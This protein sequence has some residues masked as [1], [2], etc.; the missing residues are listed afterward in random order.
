MSTLL[1]LC[2]LAT[3]DA[4]Q[5]F[6]HPLPKDSGRWSLG[7]AA[8]FGPLEPFPHGGISV[9]LLHALDESVWVGGRLQLLV[10]DTQ[11]NVTR[12]GLAADLHLRWSLWSPGPFDLQL[13]GGLGVGILHDDYL[14]VY[15]DVTR[16][17]PGLSLGLGLEARLSPALRPYAAARLL[18]FFADG[19][20]DTQ[21]LEFSV[22]VRW[23]FGDAA[24]P[25]AR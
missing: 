9:D 4:Q 17:A 10:P 23:V 12:N 18:A 25:R 14:R 5:S 20:S 19:I 21:W 13:D 11:G 3:P 7:A 22:G 8:H 16:I 2:A 6:E 1:L 24:G 15:D